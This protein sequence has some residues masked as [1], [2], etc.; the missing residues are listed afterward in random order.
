MTFR[1]LFW[2]VG[3]VAAMGL[4]AQAQQEPDDPFR[5][6][7][8]VTGEKSLD[9]VRRLNA[10]STSELTG[11]AA[12]RTL[13]SRILSILDS[14]AKI[15]S[16]RKIGGLY[17]NF[18]KD[19]KH[20][21]GLWRRTTLEEYRKPSPNWETVLDLDALGAEEKENWVWHGA[22]PL[23][24]DERFC[25]VSLSRGGADA[26]VIREFDLKEKKFVDGGFTLPEAK[27]QAYW[28][29]ADSLFVGTDFGP[30]SLTTSGYPRIVKIWK[31]GTPLSEATTVYE[32]KPDDMAVNGVRDQTP[33]FE[34]DFIH[35]RPTF[36]TEEVFFLRDGRLTK[37][38][39][40]DDAEMSVHR[41]HLFI[42]LRTDWKTG[43]KTYPAGAL[44]AAD[45]DAFMKGDRKLSVLF[46]P[47]ERRSLAGY[48]PTRGHVITNELDNVR[49]ML[50]VLTPGKEGWSRAPL[51][52][53]PEIG[54]AQVE[55]V[56]P[57]ESDDYFLVSSGF[58]SP[59][60]LALGAA[61]G[62]PAEVLKRDPTFFDADGLT[63]TQHET[64]SKDGTRVPYFEVARKDL[65]LD[66]SNPTLLYGYGGFEIPMLPS[67]RPAVG[68][69]WLEKGGVYVLANI[70][71]GGEFGP[72]WHQ[73]ALKANRHKAYE[74][75][76]AVAEDLVRRKVTSTP[77]LGTQ[78]GSNGGLLMGNMITRYPD[79]FGAVV[80]QVPLL[81]MRRYHTL[82][83][84]A[85]W[86]DEYGNPD[87]PA[88]WEFI[89]TFS[90]Y[91]NLKAGKK[92]PRTLF[93]TSTRDD[94]V[95]PGH[96][97]KMAARMKDM[98][99]DILYYENIEGGHGGAAD[100]KQQA[101]MQTLA[102]TFLWKQLK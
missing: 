46:E 2:T 16:I 55:P 50:Y 58:L 18:W 6:L 23:K 53:A 92:Y 86:M 32:G 71:G 12:F 28:R 29:G 101:F 99:L 4:A 73:S 59:N 30:G 79:L 40:P 31:R 39:K 24:P 57:D 27:T 74:D 75:F 95:H 13:E 33:G 25:L 20:K 98:N 64:T 47:G 15:P 37:V 36:W 69:G 77:H 91:H 5:W 84:G 94:R 45:F 51:A 26:E 80:C 1:S 93:T 19:A 97:R 87:V 35:R 89:R 42:Q 68:A 66:G 102:Y 72:K 11:D 41:E 7:E 21:R 49:N 61:G 100:N 67:Y 34:R 17:Y 63:V 14:D 78:G 70:R 48:A 8:D 60:T 82:L 76:A 3:L 88:E 81:D 90:P 54:T 10:E 65:K 85:S 52:G 96:A 83:A 62:G 56:D 22:D 44:L 38:E 43:G 9:W